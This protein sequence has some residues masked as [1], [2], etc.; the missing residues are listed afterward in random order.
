MKKFLLLFLSLWISRGCLLASGDN[1]TAGA[2]AVAIGNASVILSHVFSTSTNQA[3]LA[4]MTQY[5]I[6]VYSDRKFVSADINNFN[7]ALALPLT[8]RAGTFAL[9]AN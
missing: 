7:A 1:Y 9:S 4:F 5:S 3:G 2:R 6:G 8:E